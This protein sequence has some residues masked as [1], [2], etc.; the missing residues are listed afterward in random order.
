MRKI[1]FQSRAVAVLAAALLPL[2]A[3]AGVITYT[4]TYD[5][6][7]LSLGS[8]TLGG[9]TYTTVSYEGLYNGGEPG[10]PSL[11]IDY[12]RFSVPYNATNFTVSA[13]LGMTVISG[14]SHLVY[15][16]QP[17]RM[18]NDTTPVTVTLPDTSAY[19]SNTLYPSHQAWVVDDGFLAGENRIVTVA[20]MPIAYKHSSSGINR[21]AIRKSNSIY[22]RLSYDLA[23]S[24]AVNP[25]IRQ[26]DSLRNEGYE[27]T[28]KLVV[29]G[30]SVEAFSPGI[31]LTR[32]DSFIEDPSI[33]DEELFHVLDYPYLIVTTP[34][35]LHSVRRI[36]ALR[37]QKGDNVKIATIDQITNGPLLFHD[38]TVNF[39]DS[40]YIANTTAADTLRQY[41]KHAFKFW[42]TKKVLLAGT[43][44]PYWI[45][46]NPVGH[47]DLY[48]SDLSDTIDYYPELYVGRLLGKTEDQFNNYS[49]KLLRYELNPGCGN[50]SYLQSALY[51]EGKDFP[52]KLDSMVQ[53]L[54]SIFPNTTIMAERPNQGFPKGC[55]I[56]DSISANHYGFMCS[57]NHGEPSCIKVYGSD[58]LHRRFMLW[59]IDTVKVFP[60]LEDSLEIGNGLNR[61]LNR[62]YPM[63]YYSLSCST[64]PYYKLPGF[65]IDVNYGE[66]FTMGKD[67]GGPVYMGNVLESYTP[68]VRIMAE[69]FA[70]YLANGHYLLS[71]ADALS[72]TTECNLRT[73]M[74]VRHN[75]LGDPALEI[76]SDVPQHFS[77]ITVSRLNNSITVYGLD[78]SDST[79]VGYCNNTDR[80]IKK[81]VKAPSCTFNHVS[82]NGTIMVYK[83][84]YFPYIAPTLIQNTDISNSQ[85]LLASDYTAGSHVDSNLTN[86]EVTVKSGIE[87]EIEHSGKVTLGGGFKVEKGA[88]FIVKPSCYI[89]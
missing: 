44:V 26:S 31:L 86:G 48:Y 61:M 46:T 49:D 17:S 74:A 63:I 81:I 21:D 58:I 2:L 45:T 76:W 6:S 8:D 32:S 9:V 37:K 55:D 69:S 24:S 35:L 70:D 82:P 50:P 40:I 59:A 67:Y 73:L 71:E 89:K 16:C 75:Y 1:R 79:F 12:I 36:A 87:Y 18:M 72:K 25:I 83:R 7:N 13:G 57:F 53:K 29:N 41:L 28:R 33:T 66:S 27:L 78:D 43:Q 88:T 85:Y 84:N 60:Y 42:G 47:G 30:D 19:Y 62:E 23:N 38:E 10:M 22:L 65:N 52:H 68:D 77:N 15:P 54:M 11:P 51:T 14:I 3:A 20:V 5:Y 4:A 80:S 64:I 34:E 56:L 39:N